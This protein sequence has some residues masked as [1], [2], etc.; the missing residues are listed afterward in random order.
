MIKY[1]KDGIRYYDKHGEEITEGCMIRFEDGRT[2]KVYRTESGELGTDA[3]RRSWIASGKAIPCEW[4]IF[5]LGAMACEEV[6]V[7]R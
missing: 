7:I 4:G 2:E 5:P 3:T 6:E 1:L